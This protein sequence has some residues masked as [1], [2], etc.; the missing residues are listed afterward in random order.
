MDS[1]ELDMILGEFGVEVPDRCKTC[2]RLGGMV[3][4]LATAQGN[5]SYLATTTSTEVLAAYTRAELTQQA[6]EH[7]PTATGDQIADIVEPMFTRSMSSEATSNLLKQAG[8]L[9]EVEDNTINNTLGEITAQLII[10]APT[11]CSSL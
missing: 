5:K 11:G 10:C 9:M 2:P 3:T 8:Q 6:R 1:F 7:Y 4:A